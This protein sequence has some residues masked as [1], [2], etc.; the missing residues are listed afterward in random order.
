MPALLRPCHWKRRSATSAARRFFAKI[1]RPR[2]TPLI[3]KAP[4]LQSQPATPPCEPRALARQQSSFAGAC[5]AFAVAAIVRG[6][7]GGLARGLAGSASL[8]LGQLAFGSIES[9]Q[10]DVELIEGDLDFGGA[11]SLEDGGAK[12]RLHGDGF[13]DVRQRDAQ[14]EH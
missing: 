13:T 3:L 14:F 4:F 5:A 2:A 1:E 9:T 6:D 8:D 11:Q 7:V 12:R 10:V